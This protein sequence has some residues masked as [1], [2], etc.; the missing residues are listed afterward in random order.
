M[1]FP[2][3]LPTASRLGSNP[4][5]ARSKPAFSEPSV[6]SAA[7][8]PGV[9]VARDS[10]TCGNDG[11]ACS[12]DAE[13]FKAARALT[14]SGGPTARSDWRAP[15]PVPTRQAKSAQKVAIA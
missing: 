4:A 3:G 8:S 11:N 7:G 6:G 9:T 12:C 10:E 5:A 2:A 13:P 15:K 1:A 14:A